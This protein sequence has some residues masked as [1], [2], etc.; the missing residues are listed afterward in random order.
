MSEMYQ[1]LYENKNYF[2]KRKTF[3]DLQETH[4]KITI[5]LKA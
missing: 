5:K 4:N 3:C 1:I 2:R